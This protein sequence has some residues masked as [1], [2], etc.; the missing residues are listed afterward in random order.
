MGAQPGPVVPQVPVAGLH[1]WPAL[2]QALQPHR[3]VPAEQMLWHCP[4]THCWPHPHAGEH[5][6][7][8]HVPPWQNSPPGH[9]P[10]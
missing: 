2:Q 9:E 8:W 3:V 6:S 4:L 7:G 5:V 10:D 1:V